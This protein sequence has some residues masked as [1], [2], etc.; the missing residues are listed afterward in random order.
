MRPGRRH[1]PRGSG[2]TAVARFAGPGPRL[3]LSAGRE[4]SLERR[5]PWVFAGSIERVEGAPGPGDAVALVDAGD[6]FLAWA[7]YSPASQIRARVWSWREAAPVD[8]GHV[9][10]LVRAAIA[11]RPAIGP[12]E[13]MRLVH[14]E[15]DGLPGV[16]VDRYADLLVIQ[17]TSAGAEAWRDAILA[18][19]LEA[20]GCARACERSDADVREIEGLLPR[21]EMVFGEDATVEIVEDG[22]LV[23]P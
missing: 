5:H 9:R 2:H 23:L 12:A 19:A 22:L 15:A 18:A 7:A 16:V 8:A 1:A 21:A 20:T 13:A 11:R 6:R 4:K 10:E 17:L 14:G 3:K